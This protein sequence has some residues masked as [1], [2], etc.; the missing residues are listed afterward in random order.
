MTRDEGVGQ[1]SAPGDSDDDDPVFETTHWLTHDLDERLSRRLRSALADAV[2]RVQELAGCAQLQPIA[3]RADETANAS[4]SRLLLPDA[5][6]DRLG[7]DLETRVVI[8]RDETRIWLA[9]ADRL[10]QGAILTLVALD[11]EGEVAHAAVELSDPA[12]PVEFVL[13]CEAVEA[14][15]IGVAA[16]P[17]PA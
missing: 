6:R 16:P 4:T 1:G 15:A 17:A 7:S 3:V 10:P 9:G 5:L 8:S 11:A 14:V 13:A 12:D 2:E